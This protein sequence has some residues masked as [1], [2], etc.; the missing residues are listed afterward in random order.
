MTDWS[1]FQQMDPHLLVGL[2]NT[3]L[4]NEAESLQDLCR[5]H[6]IDAEALSAH[7]KAAGYEYRAE[8]GQFR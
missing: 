4:R 2:V 8:Q 6:D 7:L 3:E 1:R 5:T